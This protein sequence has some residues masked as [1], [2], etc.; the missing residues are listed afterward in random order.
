MISSVAFANGRRRSS[1]RRTAV[2]IAAATLIALVASIVQ[3]V[4]AHAASTIT[5]ES[6]SVTRAPNGKLSV[7]GTIKAT[8]HRA[9]GE[10]CAGLSASACTVGYEGRR[11]DDASAVALGAASSAG[12]S[13]PLSFNKSAWDVPVVTIDAVRAYVAGTATAYGEWVEISDPY[14][15]ATTIALTSLA[16]SRYA[17][18]RLMLTA[19]VGV[20]GYRMP[21]RLCGG[22]T[23]ST[24]CKYGVEVRRLANGVWQ[25]VTSVSTSGSNDPTTYTWTS[26]EVQVGTIDAA[27]AYIESP[28]G[29]EV[30]D[31]QS[32]SDAY[33]VASTVSLA[34]A[35][36]MRVRDGALSVTATVSV[37]GYRMPGGVCNGAV[38]ST[39]CLFGFEVRRV[40]DGV[41]VRGRSASTSG[42]GDPATITWTYADVAVSTVDAIRGF[43]E[44]PGGVV[45]SSEIAIDDPYPSSSSVTLSGLTA[46]R[47]IGGDLA[48]RGTVSGAGVRMSTGVC[49]GASGTTGAAT[50]CYAGIEVRMAADGSVARY[51]EGAWVNSSGDPFSF[52]MGGTRYWQ[53]IDAVRGYL[54]GTAGAV[55]SPWETVADSYP[56]DYGVWLDD[57][58]YVRETGLFP[59]LKLDSR[60]S[61]AGF[62]AAGRVCDGGVSGDCFIGR[63]LQLADGTT[64]RFES[65]WS[66]SIGDGFSIAGVQRFDVGIVTAVR[67]Y[68]RGAG[69]EI[70]TSWYAVAD[71]YPTA[72]Q[73]S[74]EVTRIIPDGGSATRSRVSY[75]VDA[76]GTRAPGR[77]CGTGPDDC[78]LLIYGLTTTIAVHY[79]WGAVTS[80]PMTDPLQVGSTTY[81]TPNEQLGTFHAEL[82]NKTTGECLRSANVYARLPEASES[83]GGGNPASNGCTCAQADPVNTHNGEFYLPTTDVSIPG[84]GPTVGVTRTYSAL[85]SAADGPFGYGWRSSVDVKLVTVTAGAGGAPPLAV[86]VVQEN[87]SRTRFEQQPDGSY[88]A[89]A[90]MRATLARDPVDGSWEYTRNRS[91]VFR[92]DAAGV[93]TATVDLFGNQVDYAYGTGG[94]LATITGSGGRQVMVTWSGAR[95]SAL[96]DSAGRTVSYSY[97]SSG[98][99]LS[100]TAVDGSMWSYAY[101][102]S[103][104]IYSFI[105]P[106]GGVT[107]NVYDSSGRVT[108]QTDPT[109]RITQFA[110][111]G[112]TTTTTYPDGTKRSERYLSGIVVE[113]VDAVGTSAE[114]RTRMYYDERQNLVRTV[115]AAG[116]EALSSYD[117]DGNEVA[118]TGALGRTTTRTFDA[119]GNVLTVTD[120]LGRTTS[121]SYDSRGQLLSTTSP[122]GRTQSWTYNADGTVASITSPG[123]RMVAFTYNARGQVECQTATGVSTCVTYNSAGQPTTQTDAA[124]NS[125]TS[126]FDPAGRVLTRTDVN[127]LVT[128][129]EYG[130]AGDLIEATSPLG[131]TESATYDAAGRML[132][133]TDAGGNATQFAY[134]PTGQLASVTDPAGKVTS[135]AYDVF[136]RL[137]SATDAEGRVSTRSY[138]ALDRVLTESTP[139]GKV[140][141]YAYA[142]DAAGNLT[143][144]TDPLGKVTRFAYDAAG[145]LLTVTDPLGRVTSMAYSLDGE[146]VGVVGPDSASE[147]YAYDA[148]GNLTGYTGPDGDIASYAYDAAGRLSSRTEPGGRVT[149]YAYD[150]LGQV[151]TRA[152]PDGGQISFSYDAGGRLTAVDRPG[153]DS[154]VSYAYDADGR[155]TRMV[156]ATG[157]TSYGYTATGRLASVTD[158]GG[159]TVGY[160]YDSRGRLTTLS[161]PGDDQVAYGYDDTGLMTSVTDW[162]D[163]T[164]TFA[165]TADGQLASQTLANGVAGAYGYDAAGQLLDIGYTRG[166]SELASYGYSYDAAGQLTGVT[167]DDPLNSDVDRGFGYDLRG[168]IAAVGGASGYTITPSGLVTATPEGATRSYD[169]K[170]QL[171]ASVDAAASTSYTFDGNGSRVSQVRTPTVGAV[172]T[173]GFAYT[174]AGALASVTL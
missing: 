46:A 114:R 34:S 37:A 173:T 30:S 49:P 64:K 3:V 23:E 1:A 35:S 85:S 168:Q 65:K 87:G 39:S 142:Y 120:P 164:S 71:D 93:L 118:T 50:Q 33:P 17:N 167:L 132:T 81:S 16:T 20:G 131:S 157:T 136:D 107:T 134:T 119:D 61:A 74:L 43:I 112:S 147:S 66:P 80:T 12:T 76:S 26:M 13:D 5:L 27:R 123:G 148:D 155:R 95:V 38:E 125:A 60:F 68:V 108:K 104:R 89:G 170:L 18:G 57:V 150:V 21:G 19:K 83:L 151:T 154:D 166:A 72:Q 117:A 158:G 127:G 165:W 128:S 110:Y 58:S 8:G 55:Y 90:W 152:G 2:V 62:R 94:R 121:Y 163:N 41:W 86:E 91:E 111:S 14:P 79:P 82:C 160:G 137:V 22:V 113:V 143:S 31:P 88:A 51:S 130:A 28:N 133:R 105:A 92:F 63:E 53:R 106:G 25:R 124:G 24:G 140:T 153:A 52:G 116:G 139:S 162:Q 77:V 135:Y 59:S 101:D 100:V 97:S 129:F 103:H 172:E 169:A 11:V 115:D 6:L 102:S 78:T 138:D 32:I 40:N 15:V 75:T 144:R 36:A 10:A 47:G 159:A 67:A 174:A 98:N 69:G 171:V 73:I 126:T 48:V 122:A 45:T 7:S 145:Q 149:G 141:A 84:V 99:L 70:D 29:V 9:V 156:D 56:T 109:G 44:S 161:Y 4:P 42:W 146:T 96:T 54:R